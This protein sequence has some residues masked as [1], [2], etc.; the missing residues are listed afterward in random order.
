MFLNINHFA[1]HQV[2]TLP[3]KQSKI[4]LTGQSATKLSV[5]RP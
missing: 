3:Q 5:N 2:W 1:N 4:E